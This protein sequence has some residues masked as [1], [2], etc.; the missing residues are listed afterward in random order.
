MEVERL[1]KD[2]LLYE[3]NVGRNAGFP[4]SV[5]VER[6]REALR[7][8]LKREAKGEIFRE[9]TFDSEEELLICGPKLAEA[10]EY[11]KDPEHNSSKR[12]QTLLYHLNGRL[13]RLLS[14][15]EGE[16]REI[17][18]RYLKELK[19]LSN[20]FKSRG[21]TR[22]FRAPSVV[23]VS[24]MRGGSNYAPSINYIPLE[25]RSVASVSTHRSVRPENVPLPPSTASVHEDHERTRDLSS[26]LAGLM[27]GAGAKPKIR[28]S[29]VKP[30][31]SSSSKGVAFHKWNCTFSGA[32]DASVNSFI[33]RLEELAEA[34][35]VPL[36]DLVRGAPEFLADGALIWY[37]SIK[38]LV[39]DWESL[40][41][42]LRDEFLPVDYQASLIEEVRNRRQGRDE[43]CT[44]FIACMMGLFERLDFE[45]PEKNKLEQITRNLAPYYLQNLNIKSL[46]SINHLKQEARDLEAKKNLV[47]RYDNNN[48]SRNVLEPD[49]AYK[50]NPSGAASKPFV[51]QRRP[52]VSE[53]KVPAADPETKVEPVVVKPS[54]KFSCWN[55]KS[56][57]HRFTNCPKP[58]TKFCHKCGHPNVTTKDCP[59]EKA[60]NPF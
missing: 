5:S 46:I 18:K 56:G 29:P 28:S 32:R 48:R 49:L 10:H 24:T 12:C 41:T 47:E 36:D 50:Q 30:G 33:L 8:A 22:E 16:E 43:S 55:C 21:S 51:S 52:V 3:L 13:V 19:E 54:S 20:V 42:L 4:L 7:S 6:M 15:T 14:Q 58:K 25:T 44:A 39:T 38:S 17:C 31:P 59:N 57:D 34:R 35:G 40:K 1:K 45:V 11:F 9:G 26:S 60:G 53:V 2:E 23:T 37:R 27:L